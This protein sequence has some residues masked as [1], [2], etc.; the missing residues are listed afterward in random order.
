MLYYIILHCIKLTTALAAEAFELQIEVQ[1]ATVSM[2]VTK[3]PVVRDVRALPVRTPET[4]GWAER[5]WKT[6]ILKHAQ[7]QHT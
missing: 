6:K 1:P 2:R 5:S 7:H 4:S 3:P